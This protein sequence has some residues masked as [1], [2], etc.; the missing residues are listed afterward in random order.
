MDQQ[1]DLIERQSMQLE[2]ASAQLLGHVS[3]IGQ[4]EQKLGEVT[5][6]LTERDS[7][8]YV[9]SQKTSE[10]RVALIEALR[11]VCRSNPEGTD[12]SKC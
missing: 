5:G 3:Q 12:H 1:K 6:N 8:V 9:L 11:E 7:E 10:A 4:L 2:T